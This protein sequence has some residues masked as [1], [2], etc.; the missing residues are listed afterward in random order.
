MPAAWS[1]AWSARTAG[2][3][4]TRG[5]GEADMAQLGGDDRGGGGA[6]AERCGEDNVHLAVLAVREAPPS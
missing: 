1:A 6:A 4:G 5:G 3:A 2:S